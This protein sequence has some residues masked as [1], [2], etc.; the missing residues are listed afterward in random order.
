MKTSNYLFILLMLFANCLNAQKNSIE[1]YFS[2][3]PSEINNKNSELQEYQVT[4]KWQNL[5]AINGNKN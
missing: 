3:Q 5:D 1:K 4:L 2:R